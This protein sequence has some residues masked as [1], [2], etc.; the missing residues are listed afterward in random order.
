MSTPAASWL[1][2]FVCALSLALTVLSGLLIALNLSLNAPIYF[3][4]LEPMAI[5]IGYSIIGAWRLAS[6]PPSHRLALLRYRLYGSG[7]TPLRRVRRLR[8]TGT[9]RGASGR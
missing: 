5:A 6:P 4:W 1:A 7:R 9:P 8:T 3:Y 2:W